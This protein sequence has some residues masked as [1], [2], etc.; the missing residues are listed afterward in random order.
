MEE[1]QN[2]MWL[3]FEWSDLVET[4]NCAGTGN[5]FAH[6]FSSNQKENTTEA[7]LVDFNIPN[8]IPESNL[9]EKIYEKFIKNLC[10]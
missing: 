6:E 9:E 7:F 8:H 3:C 10:T 5:S 2:R 1:F 4:A